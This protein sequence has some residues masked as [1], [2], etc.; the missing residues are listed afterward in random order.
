MNA[1]A[2]FDELA[3]HCDSVD[4]A[5]AI[6][7]SLLNM[8][9]GKVAASPAAVSVLEQ[10]AAAVPM[11]TG[12]L[13]QVANTGFKAVDTGV[14]TLSQLGP[15]ALAATVGPGYLMGHMA[16]KAMD[17]DNSDVAEIQEQELLDEL[18]TNAEQLRRQKE[19]RSAV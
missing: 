7:E 18:K 3:V 9:S 8:Q 17:V 14:N 10:M 2:I 11:A 19:L 1:L 6:T 13:S 15:W 16:G 4:Q 12:A 5:V